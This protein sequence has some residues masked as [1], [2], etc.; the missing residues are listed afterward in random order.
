MDLWEKGAR[1]VHLK[2]GFG[3]VLDCDA[4]HTVIHFDDQGRRK[5]STPLAKLEATGEPPRAVGPS[6]SMPK[7]PRATAERSTTAVGYENV[8]RQAVVQETGLAGNLPGQ[9]L[10]ILRCRACEHR[11]GA[12]GCDIHLRRCPNCDGGQPGLVY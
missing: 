10:Y 2:F 12:N 3:T 1:V 9:R 11:Y 5:L 8:N 6:G 7:R 4:Q